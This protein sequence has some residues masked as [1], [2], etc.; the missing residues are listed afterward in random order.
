MTDDEPDV[1]SGR[2][3]PERDQAERRYVAALVALDTAAEPSPTVGAT[4]AAAATDVVRLNE[5]W[6]Q[7]GTRPAG[8]RAGLF[9]AHRG[10]TGPAA[11]V[12]APPA[13]TAR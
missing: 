11:A 13:A 9:A 7:Q 2:G 10:G 1:L 4:A 12:A 3:E 8:Q 5:V 6:H